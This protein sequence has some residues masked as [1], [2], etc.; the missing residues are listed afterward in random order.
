MSLGIGGAET[1]VTELARELTRRGYSVSVVSA[2]GVY[3]KDITR[4]GAKHFFAPL[5][6]RRPLDMARAVAALSR[7]MRTGKYDIVHAHARIPAFLC[8]L[9]KP[10][11]GFRLVTTAH[12]VFN[13]RG[14]SRLFSDW[15]ERTLA[16]SGDIRDYLLRNY[17]L[18]A[19]NITVTVNGINTDKFSPDASGERARRTLGIPESAP[20]VVNV[21]RLDRSDSAPTAAVRGLL[22]AAPSLGRAISGLRIVI[23][24]GGDAEHEFRETASRVNGELGREIVTLTGARTDIGELLA[25]CDLFVGVSR[26]AL[27]ACACGKPVVLAGSEGYLGL[28]SESALESAAETN[29]TCRGHG[30][31]SAPRLGEDIAEFFSDFGTAEFDARSARLGTFGRELTASDYSVARMTD[32]CERVYASLDGPRRVVMS[33]YYGFGNA[34]DDAIMQAVHDSIAGT[35][36]G[37]EITVLSKKPRATRERYGYRAINRFNPASVLRALRRCD[38]LVFGGGSLLQDYTSTRSLLYYLAILALARALRRRVMIYANG[39]G[40]VTRAKNRRRVR[41][42]VESADVVTLRDAHS[43]A[44]LVSMGVAREDI[45]VTSDPVFTSDIPGADVRREILKSPGLDVSRPFVVF[46]VRQWGADDSFI[47]ELA[48]FGDMVNSELGFAVLLLPMH[49]SGDADVCRVLAGAMKRPAVIP[50]R[51]LTLGEYFAIIGE[52]EFTVSMRLHALIFAARVGTPSLG[53][54]VDP[55]LRAYLETL[56][57]PNLGAPGEFDA[58]RAL[59]IARAVSEKRA[60]LSDKL[61]HLARECAEMAKTDAGLLAELLER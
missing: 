56:G 44:E 48:R 22:G 6:T 49:P 61:E 28:F 18:D 59:E 5:N 40:P 1:H 10:F 26:A 46:S 13:A 23:V 15:G 29:F 57:M 60:E 12:W 58:R 33:G 45:A 21:S 32:D 7:L 53:I 2:G 11:F 36:A 37:T 34:G 8:G 20:V 4:C 55:K 41:R 54:D 16:V 19:R 27:E 3:V 25:A 39:I 38:A 35:R 31:T 24:G 43:R 9:L 42:A 47:P 50:P 30:E 52:A 51:E 17:R 14:L